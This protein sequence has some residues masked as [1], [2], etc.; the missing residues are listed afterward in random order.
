MTIFVILPLT[1]MS[2][3]VI[4]D[5]LTKTL[6]EFLVPRFRKN[7][8]LVSRKPMLRAIGM[9]LEEA[10]AGD[11]SNV[12]PRVQNVERVNSAYE[13]EVVH[14]HTPFGGGTYAQE[15]GAT[16][17]P[18]K[19]KGSRSSLR[20]K[21]ITQSI[22]VPDQI[23]QASRSPEFSIVNELVENMD[24]AMHTM[25]SEMNRQMVGNASGVLA[26]ADG[27]VTSS[28]VFTVQTNTTATNEVP[29]TKDLQEG[30]VLL[31]GTAAQVEAG[32]AQTV[33]V[34]SVDSS[35]QF[36]SATD[37]TTSDNDVI[38]RAD[39]YNSTDS[40]YN[41]IQ[42]L[43]GLLSNTGTVQ[44][45]NKANAYWFQ[46][47][48]PAAVG[49]LALADI[50]DLVSATRQ[51]APDPAAVFLMGNRQQWRRYAAL[52][53]ANRR[54]NHSTPSDFSGNLAGG[55]TGLSVFTPDGEIAFA[56]DDDVPDGIIYLVDPNGLAWMNYREFGPADDALVKDGFP[57]Q[58]KSGTLNYEFALWV[59]GNLAQTNA[60]ASGQLTGITS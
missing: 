57:G 55:A 1:L 10:N 4:G 18:G 35:T 20:M 24:G 44:N 9:P 19:F 16:L 48:Q 7:F 53:Q 41:E 2:T 51:F 27:A 8:W 56:M 59:G 45:I 40:V 26:Y 29:P 49:A 23:L 36:T 42:S 38:V 37:E 14:N 50:D 39:V 58:R 3:V 46:S 11:G 13:A 21:F 43:K 22:E 54:F 34:S 60:R 31:I 6:K 5:R 33:T 52:L 12:M 47:E 30:D 25:H 15:I 17:R 28:N 32:T